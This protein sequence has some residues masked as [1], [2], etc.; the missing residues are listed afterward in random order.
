MTPSVYQ[1]G[2]CD[3]QT[4]KTATAIV[5]NLSELPAEIAISIRSKVLS[6]AETRLVI[7]PRMVHELRFG[8]VPRRVN[9]YYRKEVTITNLHNPHDEH[10]ITF[11][12]NNVDRHNISFHS[13]FYELAVLRP[14]PRAVVGAAVPIFGR[15]DGY[16]L[17]RV[18][19]LAGGGPLGAAGHSTH[20]VHAVGVHAPSGGGGG[21]SA[22]LGG[23]DM[24]GGDMGSGGPPS[25]GELAVLPPDQ[26][27]IAFDDL[28]VRCA[29]LQ[30]FS[31]RNTSASPLRLRLLPSAAAGV[32]SL[33]TLAEAIGASAD[34][35]TPLS[36]EQLRRMGYSF[37]SDPDHAIA[38]KELLLQRLEER[39]E[40]QKS[41]KEVL[42]TS[43]VTLEEGHAHGHAW[44]ELRDASASAQ[45]VASGVLGQRYLNPLEHGRGAAAAV[46]AV[47][48]STTDAHSLQTPVGACGVRNR[49][50]SSASPLLRSAHSIGNPI[51]RE[52]RTLSG[53]HIGGEHLSLSSESLPTL[54]ALP[55]VPE[56]PPPVPP[57]AS[58]GRTGNFSPLSGIGRDQPLASL[59]GGALLPHHEPLSRPSHTKLAIPL[60]ADAPHLRPGASDLLSLASCVRDL[61]SSPAHA[62]A[63]AAVIDGKPPEMATL[64][65]AVA[66]W[67]SLPA[68]AAAAKN[69]TEIEES[70]VRVHTWLRAVLSNW[71]HS[72]DLVPLAARADELVLPAGEQRIVL[73]E[74]EPSAPSKEDTAAEGRSATAGR[75][76]NGVAAV[77]A[78]ATANGGVHAHEN[79]AGRRPVARSLALGGNPNE[80]DEEEE[81]DENTSP[82]PRGRAGSDASH[83]AGAGGEWPPV[84]VRAYTRER[85]GARTFR[86]V[87]CE[88]AISIE[89][90]EYDTSVRTEYE[91][92]QQRVA[93]R[94]N[95][96]SE[97]DARGAGSVGNDSTE[98]LPKVM[99]VMLPQ[100]TR[101]LQVVGTVCV[102]RMEIAQRSI[103]FGECES[104]M[105][106]EKTIIMH[107]RS[108][109][110][111]LYKVA[112]TGRH[113]S[114]DVQINV[115]DRR[116]CVRPFG[117][118]Q[119][120]FV[121]RPSLAGTYRET[122][123][124]HNVQDRDDSQQVTLKAMVVRADPFLLQAP[125]LDF[126]PSLLGKP[127]HEVKRIVLVNL[128]RGSRM[129]TI[130]CMP[131]LTLAG[132]DGGDADGA[133]AEWWRATMTFRLETMTADGADEVVALERA[134]EEELEKLERKLRIAI[135]KK[136][137]EKA[138]KLR[139]K[140]AAVR[141]GSSEAVSE[142][143]TD[144]S[145][146]ANSESESEEPMELP[147]GGGARGGGSVAVRRRGSAGEARDAAAETDPKLTLRLG[148]GGTQ[149]VA[150]MLAVRKVDGAALPSGC[151]TV[152][153][154]VCVRDVRD[155]E[156]ERVLPF[157]ACVCTGYDELKQAHGAMQARGRNPSPSHL[158]PPPLS[159]HRSLG[160]TWQ[161]GGLEALNKLPLLRH[162]VDSNGVALRSTSPTKPE[163]KAHKE[164]EGAKGEVAHETI[165]DDEDSFLAADEPLQSPAGPPSPP[166]SGSA[167]NGSSSGGVGSDVLQ[168]SS[169]T[170]RAP[171]AVAAELVD[172]V[173][174]DALAST[175]DVDDSQI[176]QIGQ[177][178]APAP[179]TPP[180]RPAGG[181]LHGASPPGI[182][183][184]PIYSGSPD[185]AAYSPPPTPTDSQPTNGV[186]P[187]LAPMA[188][189]PH[190]A[191]NYAATAATASAELSAASSNGA[192][193]NS[194][195]DTGGH[196]AAGSTPVP[197][198]PMTRTVR[199]EW[200]RVEAEFMPRD[201]LLK[202]V[203]DKAEAKKAPLLGTISSVGSLG[204]LIEG[205]SDPGGDT[206]VDRPGG[207]GHSEVRLS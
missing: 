3:I 75:A 166:A 200:Y 17:T 66:A 81:G 68:A 173:D 5:R 191:S 90:V 149:T 74:L 144:A 126:G 153:G 33:Y 176:W 92:R 44:L 96:E 136:K 35:V 64:R 156:F 175:S 137:P 150:V 77:N 180:P 18:L 102:S 25:I 116:G 54:P 52:S 86:K 112:K 148:R 103:N 130:E 185:S 47:S 8:F 169:P 12:A 98:N 70:L 158:P 197:P 161:A 113:A 192:L 140:L 99:P 111:L 57:P 15:H 69:H 46:S 38:K 31:V 142:S 82:K 32:L 141:S 88:A 87:G 83:P 152:H 1:L 132:G 23:G 89:L 122:L 115:E 195:V 14:Q 11:V 106:I 93:E 16:G 94:V 29:S 27:R 40:R 119:V 201:Q 7:G 65:A 26:C 206:G 188:L 34:A 72:G 207:L 61:P 120:G 196:L 9:P 55:A 107:N 129:F 79:G 160:A 184:T 53:E 179:G 121:F 21:A 117:S 183:A 199:E 171:R 125:P 189:R 41:A 71:K 164:R 145:D 110:P 45:L 163:R 114:F 167:A 109:V 124:I 13:M 181:A 62:A 2:D 50:P 78:A 204:T 168:H 157:S 128:A 134:R 30:A 67:S 108:A 155:K 151:A 59:D 193:S 56:P 20:G 100:L 60:P 165:V 4:H 203:A 91:H 43:S 147:E 84:S 133:L 123:T 178:D 49:I 131:Q 48:S 97:S 36:P 104:F 170:S 39:V 51:T 76:T 28:V 19:G 80:E 105:A 143:D 6:V 85:M 174:A 24:G 63:V 190:E 101:H 118:R 205:S 22:L 42:P 198:T 135:R 73:V 159:S 95:S 186:A 139:K 154:R 194:A 138:E 182:C 10:A 162:G 177:P 58:R 37:A 127:C 172:V 146:W 187:E 202:A